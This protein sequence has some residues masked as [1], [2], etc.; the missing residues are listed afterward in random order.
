MWF[1]EFTELFEKTGGLHS[2]E[3]LIFISTWNEIFAFS[4]S[5]VN[6]A[7]MENE[8]RCLPKERMTLFIPTSAL[9]IIIKNVELSQT[10]TRFTV[11]GII[12]MKAVC[13]GLCLT[14]ELIEWFGDSENYRR[15][16]LREALPEDNCWLSERSS[17]WCVGIIDTFLCR[18]VTKWSLSPEDSGDAAGVVLVAEGDRNIERLMIKNTQHIRI[19]RVISEVW[20]LVWQM[21]SRLI[22]LE[23]LWSSV[24]TD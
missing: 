19:W 14:P 24:K 7:L 16:N 5:I 23:L 21:G 18:I 12:A 4:T 8:L 17:E 10:I 9:I 2:N 1:I 13:E 6:I 15:N 20:F 11:T 22:W 3:L